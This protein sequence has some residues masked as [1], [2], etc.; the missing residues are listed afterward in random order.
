MTVADRIVERRGL[1]IYTLA[2]NYLPVKPSSGRWL[3]F[4]FCRRWSAV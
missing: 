3:G 2:L 1:T 4:I